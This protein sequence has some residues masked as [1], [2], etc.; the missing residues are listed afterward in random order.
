MTART[1]FNSSVAALLVHGADDALVGNGAG[2]GPGQHL[3]ALVAVC[4]ACSL[5]VS[6]YPRLGPGR[7]AALCL[8]LA[9][10]AIANGATHLIHVAAQGPGLADLTGVG[11]AVAGLVLAG[12]GA[13]DLWRHRR[14]PASPLRWL[15]R[16]AAAPATYAALGF[17]VMPVC[18]GLA[19]VHKPRADVGSAPAGY[20]AVAFAASDG[21][22]LR[23]W[24]RPS[25]TGAAV[26]VA[27]GGGS[28]RRGSLR[29]AQMLASHGYGVLV[30][31]ARGA[32]ES[33]GP[34]N[35]WGWEWERDV[36]GAA[37]FLARR[38]DVEPG[39]IGALGLSSGA[40]AVLAFAGDHPELSAVV[41][42]GAAAR[43][44]E[45][46]A[47]EPGAGLSGRLLFGVAAL[48]SGIA[49]GPPLEAAARRVRSPMLLISAARGLEYR[50]SRRYAVAAAGADHWNLRDATHT[51]AIRTHRDVYERR[52]T[53]FLAEHL[54]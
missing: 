2:V 26:L 25:R 24:Y 50:L 11:A 17:V 32:G 47:G 31:D 35:S 16:L 20:R 10:P 45:D 18:I 15:G 12:L 21:L 34:H 8:I 44:G 3:V 7:R 43:T 40:D 14:R 4:V 42:D 48:A 1:V 46:M 36:A 22:R 27:H 33:E 9:P 13:G 51:A 28:T 19:S 53:R 23:G 30:Y 6:G 52:I 38:P 29:H 37:R 49:P 54:G 41:L 39:R 5:A